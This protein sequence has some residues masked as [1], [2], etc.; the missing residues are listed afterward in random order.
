MPRSTAD[1]GGALHTIISASAADV[2]LQRDSFVAHPRVSLCLHSLAGVVPAIAELAALPELSRVTEL[3][4]SGQAPSWR[5]LSPPAEALG[6]LASAPALSGVRRLVLETNVVD[7]RGAQA[8]AAAPWLATVE[9]ILIVDNPGLRGDGL[10][11]LASGLT[12]VKSMYIARSPIAPG[13][14]RAIAAMTAPVR[15]LHLDCCGIGA[16]GARALFDSHGL[17]GIRR[18]RIVG[19]L[20]KDALDRLAIRPFT[21]LAELELPRCSISTRGGVELAAGV[22]HRALTFVDLSGNLLGDDA[23]LAFAASRSLPALAKL[24][25][26]DNDI[27]EAGAAALGAEDTLAALTLLGLTGNALKT[28]V[29]R[30]HTWEGGMWEAGGVVVEEK[31]DAEQIQE[32]FVK[33]ASLRVF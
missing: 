4:L 28:G 3:R 12:S 25:L 15:E 2:V 7:D 22:T 17:A 27:G 18:L 16:D 20:L 33:R 5:N 32:R 23:A 1:D 21:A 31:L 8:L 10:A 19:D 29:T 24:D 11:A 9:E 6:I 30:E 13:G 26:R 14:A